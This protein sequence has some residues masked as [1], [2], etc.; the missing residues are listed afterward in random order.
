VPLLEAT[1]TAAEEVEGAPWS[2]GAANVQ[3]RSMRENW[4]AR[5]AKGHVT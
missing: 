1:R 4:M 3:L 2:S 5:N